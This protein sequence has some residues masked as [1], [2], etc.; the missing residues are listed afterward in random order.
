MG[1]MMGADVDA[2]CGPKGRHDPD[3]T[4]TR[5]QRGR[6]GHLGRAAGAGAPALMEAVTAGI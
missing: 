1:A 6:G 5:R 3:R 2:L 4:A